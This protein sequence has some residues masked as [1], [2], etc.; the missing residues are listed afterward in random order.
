M[1]YVFSFFITA[2]LEQG[3]GEEEEDVTDAIENL[4]G[5]IVENLELLKTPGKDILQV[6]EK[7]DECEVID[8]ILVVLLEAVTLEH[9]MIEK[10]LE[11]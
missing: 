5:G 9:K 10:K 11:K 1:I 2:S 3:E 7:L 6:Q 4:I 8:D